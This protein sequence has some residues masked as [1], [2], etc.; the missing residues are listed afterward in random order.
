M[1]DEILSEKNKVIYR[2]IAREQEKIEWIHEQ[3]PDY[4]RYLQSIYDSMSHEMGEYKFLLPGLMTE[5]F[6]TSKSECPSDD[7]FKKYS[8]HDID[9]SPR[10]Y[11]CLMRARLNTIAD[12]IKFGDLRKI[13]NIG[14]KSIREINSKVDEIKSAVN[15]FEDRMEKESE[16]NELQLMKE[17]EG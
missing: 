4:K 12:I 2:N 8:V 13:R 9:F 17:L 10:T 15:F 16:K 7:P 5:D 3:V 14:E 11:N 1:I 6:E